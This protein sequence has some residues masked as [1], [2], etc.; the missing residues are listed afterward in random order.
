M[1]MVELHLQRMI[2]SFYLSRDEAEETYLIQADAEDTYLPLSAGESRPLTGELYIDV[3]GSKNIWF[4]KAGVIVGRL[5]V[6]S[7]GNL[8][9]CR[10]A[11]N[12]DSLGGLITNTNG[13]LYLFSDNHQV[14]IRPRAVGSNIGLWLFGPDAITNI[15]NNSGVVAGRGELYT[16]NFYWGSFANNARAA[17]ICMGI[18]TKHAIVYGNGA[19]VYLRPYGVTNGNYE[20]RV[21]TNGVWAPGIYATTG[22]GTALIIQSDGQIR[23]SSS[24]RKYKKN[25]KNVTEEDAAKGY[26]LRP[27]TFQSAIK[28]DIQNTQYGLIAEEV[29]DVLPGLA[30]Y[31]KE[32]E[33]DG[34]AYDRVCAILLKQNQMLKK[35][36][37]ALEKRVEELEKKGNENDKTK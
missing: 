12:G 31:T 37:D 13:N 14:G 29:E 25:I 26:D 23:R 35:Q 34:V 21:Q 2:S 36:V 32:G 20:F 18:T 1:N 11:S 9:C 15:Y 5:G 7:D 28:D 10:S 16:D 33:V 22:T 6:D 17:G 30:T 8:R 19:T 4:K 3:D 24:L 27:I